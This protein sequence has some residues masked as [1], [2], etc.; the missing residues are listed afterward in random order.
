MLFSLLTLSAYL[1]QDANW[2]RFLGINWHRILQLGDLRE[3]NTLATWF[4]SI[5]FFCASASFVL[6]G[7]GNDTQFQPTRFQRSVFQLA[8]LATC[9]L[10]ADEVG[11]V[12]ETVG[13]WV[14][15]SAAL[16]EGTPIYGLGYPWLLSSPF[17]TAF[18]AVIVYCLVQQTKPNSISYR[19][20]IAIRGLLWTAMI[21][22]PCVFVFEFIEAY[23]GYLRQKETFFP[24]VEE[25]LELSGMFCL[26]TANT[27]LAR[28]FRL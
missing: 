14:D 11:S 23:L 13:T 8:A 6:L 17:V 20:G 9:V 3:E 28:H 2:N 27:L 1:T 4:S 7:W 25:T 5:L 10:S 21:T 15:H 24:V 22:L 18:F 19:Q 26:L 12:H 16:L